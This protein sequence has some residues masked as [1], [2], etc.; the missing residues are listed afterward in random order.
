TETRF[1]FKRE[2]SETMTVSWFEP[3]AGYDL[4]AS[5]HGCDYLSTI[6]YEDANE[7]GSPG[8]MIT[9]GFHG[10]P[11]TPIAKLMGFMMGFMVKSIKKCLVDDLVDIKSHLE[12]PQTVHHE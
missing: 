6:R 2:A 8:T 9:V 11:K 10:T 3:N 7:N 5:S 12:S 4:T 1:M